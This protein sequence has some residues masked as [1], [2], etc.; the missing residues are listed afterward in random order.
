MAYAQ[1]QVCLHSIIQLTFISSNFHIFDVCN[2]REINYRYITAEIKLISSHT[3]HFVFSI[4][5][6]EHCKT[7]AYGNL[8][9]K[10]NLIIYLS[11]GMYAGLMVSL[12][13]TFF[14][15]SKKALKKG[16]NKS[17]KDTKK[18]INQKDTSSVTHY[19][20]ETKFKI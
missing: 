9:D 18:S 17:I 8:I 1:T 11:I 7:I 12:I 16:K 4:F 2:M 3:E 19:E 10:N 6:Y 5:C 20:T 14:C 13:Y 15:L